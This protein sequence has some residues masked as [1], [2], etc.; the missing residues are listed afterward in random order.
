MAKRTVL[1]LLLLALAVSL[2]YFF[3]HAPQRQ[4]LNAARRE[5]SLASQK[6]SSLLNRVADLEGLLEELDQTSGDLQTEVREKEERL[7]ALRAEQDEMVD[8][9]Q[10]EIADGQIQVEQLRGQLRVDM[11]NE[12]LFDSGEAVLKPAGAEVLRKIGSVL[13]KT[14]N[15]QIIVQGHTDNVAIV[16]K[17]AERY[18][19]N[20]ELSAARAINVVRFLQDEIGIDPARLAPTAFSEYQP[21]ENNSSEA[22]RQKNRRIEILVAPRSVPGYAAETQESSSPEPEEEGPDAVETGESG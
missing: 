9:L 5:A 13:K 19:T 6:A 17:L 14:E 12:I 15:R 2:Y 20:W 3:V 16:G 18:P 10:Q 8:E 11:V 1:W 4:A 7:A 22:G 21:R